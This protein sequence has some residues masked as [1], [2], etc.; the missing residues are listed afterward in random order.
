MTQLLFIRCISPL[1]TSPRWGEELKSTCADG[2]AFTPSPSGGG[3]GWG[4]DSQRGRVGVRVGDQ[5]GL[6]APRRAY[7]HQF[8]ATLKAKNAAKP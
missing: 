6:A 7:I 3:L 2:S 4:L 1:P 8:S 5:Q